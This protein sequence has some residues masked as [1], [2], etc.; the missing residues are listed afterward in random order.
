VRTRLLDRV[1][2]EADRSRKEV[3]DLTSAI[4]GLDTTNTGAPDSGNEAIVAEFLEDYLRREGLSAITLVGRTASRQNLVAS[5]PGKR[6]GCGLLLLSHSDVV[7][8][9]DLS[10]WKSPPFTPTIK[11]GRLYGRG[12][13]DMKGT[14]AAEVVALLVAHRLGLS[15]RKEVR[16]VCFADEETGGSFG[17]GWMRK[18]HPDLLRAD[19]ALNEGG[20]R[21]HRQ[22][23]HLHYGVA[24][25]EKGRH[26]VTVTFSGTGGHA[27]TPWRGDNAIAYAAEFVDRVRAQQPEPVFDKG[28]LS[29]F[30]WVP[31]FET[32]RP[33]GLQA[34]LDRLGKH[35]ESLASEMRA[36][37]RTTVTPTIVRG[38]VKSNSVPDRCE[39]VCDVRSLPQHD[40]AYVA[41][42]LKARAKGLP[43]KITL[44]TTASSKPVRS[45]ARLTA[46][47][48]QALK[49]ASGKPAEV[50]PTLT[51]G[52]TD[53]RFVREVGTPALGFAPEHPNR[54]DTADG[55]HGANE[56]IPIADLHFRARYFAAA[57]AL[58]AGA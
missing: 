19:V 29:G 24:W 12:S 42:Y 30:R 9:G 38:G 55:V 27:A 48:G 41:R 16:L 50:F 5:L 23:R 13:A 57:I 14:A 25:N 18:E 54:T 33:D 28:L 58:A 2:R 44:I 31:G 17:S 26:E 37:T 8:A 46:L 47:I 22:G 45:S 34:F 6:R 56:S 20:G 53:S 4:V 32:V 10:T 43:A 40:R 21:R 11:N 7:P 49:V 35:N 51:V 1:L 39:V 15:L 52:F 3:L 36:L